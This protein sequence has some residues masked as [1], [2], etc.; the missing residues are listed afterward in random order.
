MT[1]TWAELIAEL[2]REAGS[3]SALARQIGVKAQTVQRWMSGEIAAPDVRQLQ[4]IAA[5][6]RYSLP[7]L[8]AVANRV[9]LTDMAAGAGRDLLEHDMTLAEEE[10][11][12]FRKQYEMLMRSTLMAR[13]VQD[14]VAD[15]E[16]TTGPLDPHSQ[17]E[18]DIV[19][20]RVQVTIRPGPARSEQE[21]H[22]ETIEGI[23]ALWAELA[24]TDDPAV[25]LR[26]I[27]ERSLEYRQDHPE[28]WDWVRRHAGEVVP[29]R[30]Q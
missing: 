4:A 9:P 17:I 6:S 15:Y 26:W 5:H 7:F 23:L 29:D 22:E 25:V 30:D 24:G 27:A 19:E 11:G 20:G 16:R 12:H 10:R 21:L 14:A 1:P 18:V 2:V 3:Q 28:S 8:I 13:A